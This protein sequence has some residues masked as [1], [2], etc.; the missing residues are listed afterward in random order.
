MP[1]ISPLQDSIGVVTLSVEVGGQRLAASADLIS[2]TVQRAA[3]V[4]PSARLVF[5][6]GDMPSESF[7]LSDAADFKPGAEVKKHIRISLCVR[8]PVLMALIF[9]RG[10]MAALGGRA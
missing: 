7:P 4:V 5:N 9:G 2:V 8:A 3:N 10:L 6:D 1:G